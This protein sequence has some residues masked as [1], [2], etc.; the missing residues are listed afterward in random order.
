MDQARSRWDG[1]RLL[2]CG[3]GL[4]FVGRGT[5]GGAH[6]FEN[7]R[8]HFIRRDVA[9]V[10][11]ELARLRTDGLEVGCVPLHIL[12]LR[13]DVRVNLWY[14]HASQEEGRCTSRVVENILQM[15]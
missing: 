9:V 11:E 4:D 14:G 1:E 12:V 15:I 13:F 6:Y 5:F 8:Y 2:A 3:A 10:L 7:V